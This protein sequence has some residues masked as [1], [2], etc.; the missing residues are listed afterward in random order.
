MSTA[1][2]TPIGLARYARE[3]YDCAIAAD[4]VVGMR[5]GY[6]IHA[7]MPVMFLVAHA[8][9]LALKSYLLYS[10][11]TLDDIK[12][13]GHDLIHCWELGSTMG[14]QTHVPLDSSDL[15]LLRLLNKLHLSTEMRYIQTGT[16]ELPVFGPLQQL[17]DKI[18]NG[19]CPLAG[20]K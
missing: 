2:T 3:Y 6:E 16:K 8:I 17:T 1:R 18:L 5:K 19:I 4:R 10:G 11:K 15:E 20:Y 14:I 12:K 7:P 13:A 9:E